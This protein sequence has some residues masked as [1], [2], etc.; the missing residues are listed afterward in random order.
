MQKMRSAKEQPLGMELATPW[1]A[2]HGDLILGDLS[3]LRH[4]ILLA[5]EDS[6]VRFLHHGKVR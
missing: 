2:D 4:D 3:V 5:A 6:H 1:F